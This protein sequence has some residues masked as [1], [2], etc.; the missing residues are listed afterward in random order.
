MH[1]LLKEMGVVLTVCDSA[2]GC[3]NY[4]VLILQRQFG[5][6]LTAQVLGFSYKDS[7]SLLSSLVAKQWLFLRNW[8]PIPAHR[9]LPLSP[10]SLSPSQMDRHDSPWGWAANNRELLWQDWEGTIDWG[11]AGVMVCCGIYCGVNQA[12]V[13]DRLI[14]VSVKYSMR[15]GQNQS[16]RMNFFAS[17]WDL[18]LNTVILTGTQQHLHGHVQAS[19][20]H[21]THRQAHIPQLEDWLSAWI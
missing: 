3:W 20:R 21:V 7:L 11:N 18:I 8:N 6:D 1:L 19:F 16:A 13:K 14:G 17:Q 15:F 10:P 2:V 4:R 12:A 9:R 5:A